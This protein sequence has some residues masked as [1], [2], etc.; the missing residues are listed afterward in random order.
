M[1]GKQ[2]T[3]LVYAI[4]SCA[5]V[6]GRSF[7]GQEI[8]EVLPLAQ[9]DDVLAWLEVSFLSA[10]RDAI[11][12]E[13]RNLDGSL[14]QRCANVEVGCPDEEGDAPSGLV[15]EPGFRCVLAWEARF[16]APLPASPLRIEVHRWPDAEVRYS[17]RKGSNPIL[18]LLGPRQPSGS[19]QRKPGK[20]PKS[21]SC[22]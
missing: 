22:E 14:L 15:P 20:R 17:V 8:T 19:N 2:A 6:H 4:A 10:R 12:L 3:A 7:D 9:G 18:P 11:W 5:C 21:A 16:E 13:V 1:R